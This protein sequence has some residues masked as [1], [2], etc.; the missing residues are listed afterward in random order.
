MAP[1]AA[2]KKGGV[3]VMLAFGSPKKKPKDDMGDEASA[4]DLVKS[5][6]DFDDEQMDALHEYIKACTSGGAIPEDEPSEGEEY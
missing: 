4:R 3:D 6:C 2:P 1:P 5:L